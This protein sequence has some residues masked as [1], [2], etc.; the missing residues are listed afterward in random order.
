MQPSAVDFS[1]MLNIKAGE[2]C[3]SLLVHHIMFRRTHTILYT[4]F[5]QTIFLKFLLLLFFRLFFF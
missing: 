3:H 2:K 1:V 4:R 5:R